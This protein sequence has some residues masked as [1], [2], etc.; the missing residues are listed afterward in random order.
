VVIRLVYYYILILLL[1]G[2]DMSYIMFFCIKQFVS[3]I[4]DEMINDKKNIYKYMEEGYA[5][6]FAKS[7]CRL[8]F[9]KFN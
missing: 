6:L 3:N 4:Y 1:S 5:N 8:C 7:V 2:S 9:L